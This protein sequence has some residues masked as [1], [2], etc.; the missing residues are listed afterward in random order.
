[1]GYISNTNTR[2]CSS[3]RKDNGKAEEEEEQGHPYLEQRTAR[4]G[5]AQGAASA[6]SRVGKEGRSCGRV[7]GPMGAGILRGAGSG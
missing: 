4:G 3:A 6:G 1:M 5:M 7:V 2:E